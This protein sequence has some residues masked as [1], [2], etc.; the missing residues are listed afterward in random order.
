[1]CENKVPCVW[2]LGTATGMDL[3]SM[4]EKR[5]SVF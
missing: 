3:T 2:Y 5:A 1:M 4:T